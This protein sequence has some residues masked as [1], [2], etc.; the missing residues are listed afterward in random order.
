MLFKNIKK[1]IDKWDPIGLLDFAPNDEYVEECQQILEN[2]C[3]DT[4]QLGEIIFNIFNNYFEDSFTQSKENCLDIA[5]IIIKTGDGSEN[6]N[7]T[8]DGTV[9]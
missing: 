4:N 3:N 1:V 9:S 6:T 7:K 5:K 8:G 2:Y